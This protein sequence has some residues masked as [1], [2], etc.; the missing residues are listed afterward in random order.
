MRFRS[1]GIGIITLACAS[2]AIGGDVYK[3]NVRGAYVYQDTPCV[4]GKRLDVAGSTPGRSTMSKSDPQ[5]LSLGALY[6]EIIARAADERRLGAD[7]SA[8]EDAAK[9]RLGSRNPSLRVEIERIQGKWLPQIRENRARF[10]A[11]NSEVRRRCPGGASLSSS[12][13]VCGK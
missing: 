9:A 3:C 4:D 12:R 6:S 10:D 13:Q 2:T 1:L 7:M 11:L 5:S 8:E